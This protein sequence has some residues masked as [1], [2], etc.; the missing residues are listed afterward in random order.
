MESL[1]KILYGTF[2]FTFGISYAVWGRWY[3]PMIFLGFFILV[4]IID[5]KKADKK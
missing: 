3:L 4:A 2:M 1:K 5:D